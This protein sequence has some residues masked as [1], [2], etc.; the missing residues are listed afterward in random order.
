MSSSAFPFNWERGFRTVP[1]RSFGT[2]NV[3]L[4][5]TLYRG[6]PSLQ[7]AHPSFTQHFSDTLIF[8]YG[9]LLP[10]PMCVFGIALH[11]LTNSPFGCMCQ[12]LAW[13]CNKLFIR[14]FSRASEERTFPYLM[15]YSPR[16][17]STIVTWRIH[18]AAHLPKVIFRLS[19]SGLKHV[20][21]IYLLLTHGLYR[22]IRRLHVDSPK[23]SLMPVV[24]LAALVVART[25]ACC[26]NSLRC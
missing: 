3:L 4:P 26:N 18:C 8:S 1:T 5:S 10:P 20:A 15:V 16:F 21:P 14:M 13:H 11:R 6:V 23:T 22:C 2:C 9:Y 25:A 19:A 17:M 12:L 7:S 24:F